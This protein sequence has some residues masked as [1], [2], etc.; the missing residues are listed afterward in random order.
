MEDAVQCAICKEMTDQNS[1][2]QCDFCNCDIC[3]KCEKDNLFYYPE[4]FDKCIFCEQD[5]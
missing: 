4:G 3:D 2:S 5:K 1:I